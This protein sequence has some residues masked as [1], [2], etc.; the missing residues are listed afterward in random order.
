MPAIQKPLY[1]PLTLMDREANQILSIRSRVRVP[2]GGGARGQ[3]VKPVPATAGMR[4][5]GSTSNPPGGV[6]QPTGPDVSKFR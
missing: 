6:F 1:Y 2:V 4:A 5:P 3:F